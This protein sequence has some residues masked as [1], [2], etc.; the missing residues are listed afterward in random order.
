MLKDKDS[1][2]KFLRVYNKKN[3]SSNCYSDG[4]YDAEVRAAVRLDGTNSLAAE[5]KIRAMTGNYDN[6]QMHNFT[7]YGSAGMTH[8]IMTRDTGLTVVDSDPVQSIGGLSSSEWTTLQAIYTPVNGK[9]RVDYYADG[10]LKGTRTTDAVDINEVRIA[11]VYVAGDKEAW[12]D[13]DDIKVKYLQSP[14]VTGTNLENN[15]MPITQPTMT[16]YFSTDMNSDT[17]NDENVVVKCGDEIVDTTVMYYP[18]GNRCVIG[19]KDYLTPDS[20]YTVRF[21][22]VTSALGIELAASFTFRSGSAGLTYVSSKLSET[23]GGEVI[24]T[25]PSS[26]N[27]YAEAVVNN[28]T[29]TDGSAIV[30]LA[31]YDSDGRLINIASSTQENRENGKRFMGISAVL[32][33][34]LK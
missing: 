28:G 17:I 19:F 22:N 23:K 10:V 5:L 30:I 16:V 24:S 21:N 2:N 7:F 33:E 11:L 6:V 25:I 27:V 12:Y 34:R 8:G 31:A 15:V 14:Y 32:P 20:E 26:G 3:F 13:I 1:G 9:Y 29:G 4:T 18:D